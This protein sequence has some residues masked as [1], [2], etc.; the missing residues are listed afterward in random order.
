MDADVKEAGFILIFAL[1]VGFG[2]FN[3]ALD[4]LAFTQP[5]PP[6]RYLTAESF[7]VPY[8][9][10]HQIIQFG[11]SGEPLSWVTYY[12]LDEQ[13]APTLE[14]PDFI[15]AANAETTHRR[16]IIAA[17]R[18]M[19]AGGIS[20]TKRY[21]LYGFLSSKYNWATNVSS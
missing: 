13:V 5:A 2:Y 18:I 10:A 15:Q 1:F 7:D 3:V 19:T 14:F 8:P 21:N 20:D 9:E 12:T 17:D 11:P 6:Y 4:D 16:T